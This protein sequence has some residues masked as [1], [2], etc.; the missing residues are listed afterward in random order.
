M[1]PE[2]VRIGPIVIS[3]YGLMLALAFLA[4]IGIANH[5]AQKRGIATE[6]VVNLSFVVMISAIIG[7]RLLYVLFHLNEF[8]GRWLYTFIPIQRD[9]TIGLSGL[10]LLGGV[11]GAVLAGAVYLW[12]KKLPIWKFADSVAPALAF[13]IF[14]G[15]IGCFLNGCCFGKACRFPWGVK[16][17]SNSYAGMMMGIVPIHPTQLYASFYGLLIFGVLLWIERRQPFD[18]FLAAIFLILY[19]IG[20]FVIDFFRFYESQMFVVYGLD[21]NQV[22]SLVMILGGIG[23]LYLKHSAVINT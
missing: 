20:R 5:L 23:I 4:G 13:G 3:S 17:P 19:G 6:D 8:S 7:A 16:F 18:G 11:G 14:I 1:H 15:R 2:L 10:I 12:K 9:G 22:V 21:F